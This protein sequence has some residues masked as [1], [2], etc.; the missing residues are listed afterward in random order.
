MPSCVKIFRIRFA[1]KEGELLDE[2]ILSLLPPST[3]DIV[4][5]SVRKQFQ[6]VFAI[7]LEIPVDLDNDLARRLLKARLKRAGLAVISVEVEHPHVGMFACQTVQ[8]VTAAVAAPI[9]N[10]E[11]FVRSGIVIARANP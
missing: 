8:L 4:R 1:I 7:L 10:K 6:N 9:V 3:D 11:N 5:S 2:T